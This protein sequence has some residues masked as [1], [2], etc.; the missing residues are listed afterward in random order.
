MT[1]LTRGL[2]AT[3]NY[4][5][6]NEYTHLHK[7]RLEWQPRKLVKE[8]L[9]VEIETGFS[10]CVALGLELELPVGSFIR[11]V[12][13]KSDKLP[14]SA[15]N[16]LIAN[17]IDEEKHFDAFNQMRCYLKDEDLETAKNFRKQCLHDKT[18]PLA[19]ARD[20]ESY[21]FLPLQGFMRAYSGQALERVIADISHDEYRHTNYNWLLSND[22]KIK[23]FKD[24]EKLCLDIVSW[25]VKG[26][27]VE[28]LWENVCIDIQQ[29]GYSPVLVSLLN[30]GIH[31]APF[32][33][34]NANY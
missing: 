4:D 16:G 18:H 8:S 28:S 22:L 14:Q 6:D 17:I 5:S 30:Y 15:I 1:T 3:D 2:L 27:G 31:R 21:V 12:I 26:S 10:R 34:S 7:S 20:L 11:A 9:P 13:D 19:K 23:R 29:D 32:E 24:F 25:C 33:I